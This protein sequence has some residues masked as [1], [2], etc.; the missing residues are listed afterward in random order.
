MANQLPPEWMM[1]LARNVDTDQLKAI[2]KDLRGYNP[3]PSMGAASKAT[4]VGAGRVIDGDDVKR[5]TTGWVKPPQVNDWR[6]PGEAA[7]NRLMD[8]ED[9]N[10]RAQRIRELA[11]TAATRR[12]LAEAEKELKEKKE[13]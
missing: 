4:P 2:V 10:F 8:Q 1:D 3:S 6:P 11:E 9:L 12:V 13:G 7:L 5:G